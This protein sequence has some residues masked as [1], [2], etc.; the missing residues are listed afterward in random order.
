[1]LKSSIF[2]LV[3]LSSFLISVN[4]HPHHLPRSMIDPPDQ[5]VMINVSMHIIELKLID[6]E[7]MD[8]LIDFYYRE[9]WID[10]RV[11]ESSKYSRDFW[12]P[13]TFSANLRIDNPKDLFQDGN[14]FIR[15]NDTSIFM[16]R[17]ISGLLNCATPELRFFPA[18]KPK[19]KLSFESYGYSTDQVNYQWY[20]M[21][22]VEYP[23]LREFEVMEIV[24]KSD[25]IRLSSGTY[26]TITMEI[27]M[28]RQCGYYMLTMYLPSF[29]IVV[30]SWMQFCIDPVECG[31]HRISVGVF[32]SFA[33]VL[34]F[35]LTIGTIL[36]HH[37]IVRGIDVYLFVS[38][39][40]TLIAFVLSSHKHTVSKGVQS[41]RKCRLILPLLYIVFNIA[42]AITLWQATK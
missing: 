8:F 6:E 35:V 9:R 5:P 32:T 38:M 27:K 12:I 11:N 19:C 10:D 24:T 17:R 2:F 31:F 41:G 39:L 40:M 33:S 22:N 34:M 30:L 42:Y 7:K 1:M 4:G 23:K 25:T 14:T 3:I 37:N 18:D 26:G 15:I 13:D 16:S 29:L 36:P 21:G 28:K 20:K